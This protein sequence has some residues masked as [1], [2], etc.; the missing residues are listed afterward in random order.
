MQQSERLPE[1]RI[2]SHENQ[3][4]RLDLVVLPVGHYII[5]MIHNNNI[6]AESL[7]EVGPFQLILENRRSNVSV[8]C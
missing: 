4:M 7:E 1:K 3:M 6:I 8:F 2:V 5:V